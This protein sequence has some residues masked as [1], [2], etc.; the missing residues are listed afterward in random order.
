MTT[1]LL[2]VGDTSGDPYAA[3]LVRALRASR[4]AARFVGLGGEAMADAGVELCVHQHSLAVGG[5]V[6]LAGSLGRIVSGWKKMNRALHDERPDLAILI[7]TADFNVPFARR[8]QRA[9][10][11]LLYYVLPQ[12]WAWRRRRIHKLRARSNRLAVIFPF[13]AD[14]YRGE[15]V[16]AEFVGHPLVDS[17][18]NFLRTV[19][20]AGLRALLGVST[21]G[22]LLALLPGSRRNELDHQLPLQLEIARALAKRAPGLSCVLPVAASL[23]PVQVETRVAALMEGVVSH[24]PVRV[25]RNQ[26]YEAIRAC[27]VALAKPGTVTLET[28]LLGR[29]LVVA[30]RGN[31]ISAAILRRLVDVPAWSMPNLI[32]GQRVVPEFLQESA[33]PETVA[34][35]L[36]GL[37]E[38]DSARAAQLA[39][40]EEVRAR[41]GE[42]GA[43]ERVAKIAEEL[44]GTARA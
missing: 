12:V 33:V 31:A 2:S 40:F 23:D 8:V 36:A 22:P 9:G 6:E 11:P 32:A 10:V 30:G 14:I 27:D 3:D 25:V 39:S 5:I 42:G 20:D 17:T 16:D 21:T 37:L 43:T 13:E 15:G 38:S 24:P 1:V 7:D 35:E 28:A 41:L 34:D 4:P 44:L 19:D 29:P 18:R 26:T